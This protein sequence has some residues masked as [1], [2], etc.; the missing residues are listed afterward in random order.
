MDDT[1]IVKLKCLIAETKR[2]IGEMSEL[3]MKMQLHINNPSESDPQS[4][5]EAEFAT[6]SRKMEDIQREYYKLNA[7]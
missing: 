6:Y 1:K 3:C 4:K 5:F 7:A 2:V